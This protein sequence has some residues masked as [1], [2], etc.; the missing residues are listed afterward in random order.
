MLA[1]FAGTATAASRR[2]VRQTAALS[3]RPPVE[4][5]KS[6]AAGSSVQVGVNRLRSP[7]GER[8]GGLLPA[9]P[10]DSQHA[11]TPL[12]VEVSRIGPKCLRDPQPVES[13]QKNQS[14]SAQTVIA[15]GRDEQCQLVTVKPR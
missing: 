10:R 14:V 13:K 3:S 9:L 1:A 7:G 2:R 8:D 11:V 12:S 6:G 4:V 5:E 15:C